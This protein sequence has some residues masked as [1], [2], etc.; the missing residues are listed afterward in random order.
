MQGVGI[1]E[2]LLL[3]KLFFAKEKVHLNHTGT[4][5]GSVPPQFHVP[6]DPPSNQRCESEIKMQGVGFEPTN[7][8]RDGVSSSRTF[9]KKVQTPK[10]RSLGQALIPLRKSAGPGNIKK[11]AMAHAA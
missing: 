6:P 11:F 9:R 1:S 4:A 3:V 8:Q 2:P 10:P 7:P 5:E